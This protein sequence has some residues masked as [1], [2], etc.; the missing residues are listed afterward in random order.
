MKPK[1]SVGH[2]SKLKRNNKSTFLET[3]RKWERER[4]REID[5]TIN[6]SVGF[7]T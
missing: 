2:K 3:V 5:N 7:F 4:E 6:L 1:G